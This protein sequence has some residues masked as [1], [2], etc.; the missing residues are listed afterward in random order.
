MVGSIATAVAAQLLLVASGVIV[1]RALG[2]EDRG[3]VALIFVLVTVVTQA[4]SLGAPSAVTYWIAAR[5]TSAG[6]LLRELRGFRIV[7]LIVILAVHVGLIFVVLQPRTSASIVLI[8]CL[9]LVATAAAVSQ[10][11]G[12]AV[13]QGL[14]RFGAFNAVRIMN[15]A[16][17]T[18]AVVGLWAADAATLESVTIAFV[19]TGVVA[20]IGT[21]LAVSRVVSGGED[22]DVSA[23]QMVSFGL[24]SLLGS[25]PPVE[26][27]RLDQLLV[28]LVLSPIALG[29][30]VV[31]L[32]FTNLSRLVGQSIGMV[33]FPRVT[34]EPDRRRKLRLVRGDFLLGCVVC[35]AATVALV[36]A[37][38]RLLPFFFG[39]AFE[40]A[41]VPAQVLL[42]GAF[43]AS[44]RRILVDATRGAGWPLWGAVAEAATLTVVPAVVIASW[45][46]DS[47]TAVAV[48]VTAANF[49]GLLAVAPALFSFVYGRPHVLDRAAHVDPRSS[50]AEIAQR[51]L[52]DDGV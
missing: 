23:R 21:W 8:G 30:Y 24:R 39:S 40:P 25:S 47:L 45:V 31:A 2:P 18:V 35:G 34:A 41:V 16:L 5:R 6:S 11:Y 14:R 43:F 37:V 13:L 10:M 50:R 1:A 51:P 42:V 4:G 36:L 15:G 28:G 20:A 19:A 33:T 52:A 12:L 38:P 44:V 32:A 27:F 29:Y 48:L 49:V 7:Q 17:Y 22:S 9:S 46:T 26:T 3:V